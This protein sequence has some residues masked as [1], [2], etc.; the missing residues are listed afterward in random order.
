MEKEL[1]LKYALQNAINYS[2]KANPGAVIGK[3]LS[4]N[5]NLKSKIKEVSKE[6]A[7]TVEEVNKLNLQ[8]QKTKL[9]SLDPK[10]LEKKVKEKKSSI[11][12]LNIKNL[13]MRFEPSPS[14]ALH[15]GHVYVLGLNYLVCKKNNGRLIVR[16]ADTDP[17]NI[18]KEAYELIKKDVSWLTDNSVKEFP[19]QSDR[20]E[21][22]YKYAEKILK[23]GK[24]YIC[25]CDPEEAKKKLNNQEACPCRDLDVKEQLKRWKLMFTDYLPGDAVMRIKTDLSHKNPAMRDWPAFRINENVHPRAGRKYRVWPLMNF[26]VAIDDHDMGVTAAI[27]AKE[28]RDNEKRQKYL[29]DY[30]KWKMPKNF[31]VGR[32]NFKDLRISKSATAKLIKESKVAGWDDPRLPFLQALKRR[33]YQPEALLKYAEEIGITENDKVVSKDDFFKSI[34]SFNRDL[35]DSKADRHFFILEPY[36]KIKIKK[37]IEKNV[38]LDLYPSI[39]LGG[40]IFHTKGEFFIE[41]KLNKGGVYRL[42]HLYNIKDNEFLSEEVDP[43]LNA[44]MIHW[45]PVNEKNVEVEVLMEDNTIKKGLAEEAIKK[46]KEKE[47]V[48]AERFGFLKLEDRK[49]MRFIYLHR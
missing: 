18:V 48:Q 8:E 14:G 10:L 3:V 11:P 30:F 25:T 12:K 47:I 35:I 40:R 15:V 28:H 13:V 43:R 38:Q 24:A 32:I 7:K 27:R 5:P 23:L 33:G 6:I 9:A 39:R 2:G 46:V 42:M 37:A 1:I 21:T 45:L 16:I 26:S 41:D 44:K 34:N 20:I 36:K 17:S 19:I 31:Y 4:E 29:Y 49:K 22:Y